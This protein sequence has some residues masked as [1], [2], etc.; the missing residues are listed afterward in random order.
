MTAQGHPNCYETLARLQTFMDRE[1]TAVEIL[2]SRRPL[3]HARGWRA[4]VQLL[5]KVLE[6]RAGP[7]RCDPVGGHKEIIISLLPG[8]SPA[9]RLQ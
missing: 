6:V 7:G 2:A 3:G 5:R 9:L 8:A 1:L 4:Q